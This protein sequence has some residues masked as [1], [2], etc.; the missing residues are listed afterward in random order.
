MTTGS[1]P[2]TI[3]QEHQIRQSSRGAWCGPK[4]GNNDAQCVTLLD[5]LENVAIHGLPAFACGHSSSFVVE[6]F[7]ASLGWPGMVGPRS[8]DD[9]AAR[10]AARRLNDD[11][12]FEKA[13]R[14]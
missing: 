9:R 4:Q 11:Y 12:V 14:L 10:A 7:C 6:F 3:V 5:T 1:S 13:E 8:V 2:S